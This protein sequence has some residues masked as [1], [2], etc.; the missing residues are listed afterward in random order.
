[1]VSFFRPPVVDVETL[2][3]QVGTPHLAEQFG[4]SS[5][6]IFALFRNTDSTVFFSSAEPADD[7]R[8]N[9]H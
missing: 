5:N 3:L 1:M 4:T 9:F 2:A 8:E 7:A 6:K